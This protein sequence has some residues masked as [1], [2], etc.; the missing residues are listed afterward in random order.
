[1]FITSVEHPHTRADIMLTIVWWR[2]VVVA[3]P[4]GNTISFA[5]NFARVNAVELSEQR[6]VV[7]INHKC[8]L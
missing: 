3:V 5:K 2:P 1:V 6:W 8:F 7:Y 4:G